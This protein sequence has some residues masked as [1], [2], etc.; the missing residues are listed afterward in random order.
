MILPHQI[1]A[2]P[3]AA[4]WCYVLHGILGSK[5]NWRGHIRRV[6]SALPAWGFVLVDLRNHG[7]AQGFVPP[8][9]LDAVADD[10]IALAAHLARPIDAVIGHSFGAK[11]A[12]V[13][14]EH[15]RGALDHAVIVD[16][17]PGARPDQRASAE[18]M[19]ALDA[20]AAVGR[21]FASRDAFVDAMM[22]R[23]LTR[24]LAAW[25]AMNVVLD[26]SAYTLR[27]DLAVIRT[28]LDDY[29]VRDLWSVVEDP[30]GRVRVHMVLGGRSPAVDGD[31]RLRLER[32]AEAH[33]S[34]LRVSV[35]AKAGHWVHVD[36]PDETVALLVETLSA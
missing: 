9:T 23:G 21:S 26:G 36:A 1:V 30:P 28:M 22:A 25:L 2:P 12:L 5:T 16:G 8:H 33:P 24:D 32:A 7:D 20:L 17:N 4:R 6:S 34:R 29:F 19:L 10:V 15:L 18:T 3:T 27:L 11:S 14:T 13:L 31:E 35:V